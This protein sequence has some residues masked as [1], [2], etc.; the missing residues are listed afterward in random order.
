MRLERSDLIPI[1]FLVLVTPVMVGGIVLIQYVPWA[2]RSHE[3]QFYA[4]ILGVSGFVVVVV[5]FFE[6]R[7]RRRTGRFEFGAKEI[8]VTFVSGSPASRVLWD[9]VLSYDDRD[10]KAIALATRCEAPELENLSVAVSAEAERERLVALLGER[11]V[12]RSE[13]G[14]FRLPGGE[15]P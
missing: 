3:A 10:P 9:Q 8:R 12:P 4:V 15:G 5:R 14:H 6:G 13:A 1:V 11:G 7:S 2:P